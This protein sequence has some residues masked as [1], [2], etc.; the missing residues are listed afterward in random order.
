MTA[1]QTILRSLPLFALATACTAV[2]ALAVTMFRPETVLDRSFGKALAETQTASRLQQ[3]A[4][5][6]TPRLADSP[7]FRLSRHDDEVQLGTS[8]PM[9]IGDRIE[10]SGADGQMRTLEVYDIRDVDAGL[11]R[12]DDTSTKRFQIVSCREIGDTGIGIV[13]FVIETEQTA[14]IPVGRPERTL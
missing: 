7:Y 4:R 13:R 10:I 11:T 3:Q 12:I 8:K 6:E 5:A 14:P 1:S 9:A 2:G